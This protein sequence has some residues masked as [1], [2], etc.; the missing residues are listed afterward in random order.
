MAYEVDFQKPQFNWLIELR[1]LFYY[2]KTKRAITN[3][4]FIIARLLLI[5]LRK[6]LL[7]IQI[8]K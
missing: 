3:S 7:K 2:K 5:K 4:S 6:I 1:L 8:S